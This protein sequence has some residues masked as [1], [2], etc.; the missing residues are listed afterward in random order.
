MTVLVDVKGVVSLCDPVNAEYNKIEHHDQR[1][2]DREDNANDSK[3]GE[4]RKERS[5]FHSVQTGLP[6]PLLAGCS[7]YHGRPQ[8]PLK[9]SSNL[10][11]CT[12]AVV[13]GLDSK[14]REEVV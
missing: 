8:E 9:Q 1:C 6:L 13:E 10:Q 3:I 5:P 4:R 7:V 14:V 2:N 11:Q 12:G